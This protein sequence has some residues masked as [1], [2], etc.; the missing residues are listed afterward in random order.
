[1]PNPLCFKVPVLTLFATF[2]VWHALGSQVSAEAVPIGESTA[3]D[4]APFAFPIDE[5]DENAFGLR[6]AEPRKIRRVVVVF[7]PDSPLPDPDGVRVQ[8]WHQNWDGRPEALLGERGAGRVGWDAMDDWVNGQWKPADTQVEVDGRRWTFTFNPTGDK[9]FEGLGLAG[10][11]YRKTLM[12]R[13]TSSEALPRPVRL[14]ALTDA[15]NRMLTVR[16]HWGQPAADGVHVEGNEHLH[17]EVFSGEV[18]Q[19]RPLQGLTAEA[20]NPVMF[21]LP[22]DGKGSAELD[23]RMAAN[24]TGLAGVDNDRTILT[25]RSEYRPFSFAADEVA[26]GDRILV[27]DLGILVTRA[28]DPVTLDEHRQARKEFTGRT[29]YDR[30]FDEPE[31][32]LRRAWGDMPLKRPLAFLHGLPGNRNAFQ[33]HASGMLGIA[34]K[35]RWFEL[36]A[37][38]RDSERKLWNSPIYTLVLGFPS[39]DQRGGRSLQE[40]YLPILR[41][42][43]QDGPIF[44]EQ[45]TFL[46]KLDGDLSVVRL[47]DPTVLFMRVRVVNTSADE[48]GQARFSFHKYYEPPS[49]PRERLYVQGDRILADYEGKPCLRVLSDIGGRGELSE[50]GYVLR[51]SLDLAPGETHQ[52]HAAVPSITLTDEVEIDALRGRDFDADQ[53]RVAAYWEALTEPGMRI[54]TPEP[55]INDFHKAHLRHLLVNCYKELDSDRLHAHVG[56]FIYGV[57]P[58]ESC[59]MISDLDRRGYTDEARRCLDTFLHYQGTVQFLG[60]YQSKKGMFYGA[61][62]HETGHYNKSHGYVLWNMAEHWRNTRDRAWMAQAAPKLVEAC[63]WVVRERQATMT[64]RPDGTRPIEYGFLPAGSLEDIRDFWYWLATNSAT[65][66]GFD[67]L[68]D[69]LA[70]FGHP[71]ADRLLREAKAYH[72]DVMRG[73]TESRIITPVVRLRDGTCVPKYP[74]RLYERGRC[75]GWIRETLE[76]SIFLPAY[77]LIGPDKVE[78]KWILQDYEDN[79]YISDRYGYQIPVFENFWFSRGGFS[80]QSNLLDGPLPYLHRDEIQHYVRACLNG[81]A[82]TFYPEI[83]MC[84]EHALPELGYAAGDFFKS[85]DEAQWNYWLRLMFVY[86]RE[87]ELHLGRAIPRYW[88]SQ[89][90]R[91]GIERAVTYFGPISWTMTSDIDAGQIT[92]VVTPPTRNP[93]ET[94]YMRFRHPQAKPIQSVEVNGLPYDRFD[95]EKEW[96]VLPGSAEGKQT[97]VVTYEPKAK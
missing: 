54:T 59:M 83:R 70:D 35:G 91:I 23:I 92:A 95:V 78:S 76:G 15:V 52:F 18:L 77:G 24:P 79:L 31:Q 30:V 73:L 53:K 63:D 37:S 32:T 61:G 41:T 25:V 67:A 26:R 11:T 55:W 71:E 34:G 75:H 93:P 27:D 45:T 19:V 68:A 8:Y 69:A 33:Q 49:Y 39:E 82:S 64:V 2:L 9:E 58:N 94:I 47:D 36:D 38:P 10:V 96:V 14:Q 5:P 17:F 48:A 16:L 56:T 22:A 84:A 80:M 51:W 72:D 50:D 62:G 43:W 88:L 20:T 13:I 12:V 4:A 74:S 81:F 97:I 65:V 40:G 29:V 1:M 87:D 3:F 28:D 6:W 90:E 60:D 44:Y 57:Y 46:D 21:R 85:S 7:P 42:W 86:E 66:W 89:G